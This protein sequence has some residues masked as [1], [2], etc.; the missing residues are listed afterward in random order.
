MKYNPA[1][2]R[3]A[4]AV[5]RRIEESGQDGDVARMIQVLVNCPAPILSA[6]FVSEYCLH[7]FEGRTA[8]RQVGAPAADLPGLVGQS[9][10][11]R[12]ARL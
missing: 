2:T 7:G 1:T 12:P 6:R 10:N 9:P 5:A 8:T 11:T 3:V 4:P